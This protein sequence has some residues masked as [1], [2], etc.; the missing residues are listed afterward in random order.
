MALF[1]RKAL[2]AENGYQV[3]PAPDWRICALC[4]TSSTEKLVHPLNEIRKDLKKDLAVT[5][6]PSYFTFRIRKI[7]QY[8]T[9]SSSYFGGLS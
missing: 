2:P 7:R 8:T 9:W 1:L 6:L 3:T 4:Q 5:Y